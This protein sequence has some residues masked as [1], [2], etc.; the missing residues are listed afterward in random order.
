MLN[1]LLL[2]AATIEHDHDGFYP[3]VDLPYEMP[4]KRY[5]THT[6]NPTDPP[7]PPTDDPE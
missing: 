6:D 4:P 2:A 1:M 7:P 5:R 3:A